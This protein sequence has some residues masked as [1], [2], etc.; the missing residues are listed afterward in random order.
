MPKTTYGEDGGLDRSR[1]LAS[2]EKSSIAAHDEAAQNEMRGVRYRLKIQDDIRSQ[3]QPALRQKKAKKVHFKRYGVASLGLVS[4]AVL[5][6]IALL[7]PSM[8]LV[9]MK[10]QLVNDLNDSTLAYYTYAKKVMAE[11]VGGGSCQEKT[12]EC[13]FRSM[14]TMLKERYEE[15]GFTLQSSRISSSDRHAVASIRAPGGEQIHSAAA[16]KKI[17]DQNGGAT[18]RI[19][20]VLDPK[21]ALFHDRKF[22]D[23]LYKKFHI[24]H[25]QTLSGGSRQE[26]EESFDRN[27]WSDDDSIDGYGRGVFGLDYLSQTESQW[28]GEIYQKI[29]EKAKT[30]LA[31]TCGM[32]TYAT[33]MEGAIIQAKSTTLARFAMQYLAT[34]DALKAGVQSG[35]QEVE[36]LADRLSTIDSSGI[37]A[38][39]GSSYRVPAMYESPDSEQLPFER[40]YMNDA[41]LPLKIVQALGGVF[42]L[43]GTTY[44]QKAASSLRTTPGR[45][46]CV[47]GIAGAQRAQEQS[48]QCLD[49]GIGAVAQY[50]GPIGLA[51]T[52]V[53]QFR[54]MIQALCAADL[55]AVVKIAQTLTGPEASFATSSLIGPALKQEYDKF[56]SQTYGVAA[57]DAIFSGTGVL[58]G[59]VAQSI[60]MR[61]ASKDSLRNYL[62]STKDLRQQLEQSERLA[63]RSAP[64]DIANPY[65]FIG[66]VMRR[67][68]VVAAS[69]AANLTSTGLAVVSETFSQGLV[70]M[71][72][73]AA[74][75]L[76]SQPANHHWQRLLSPNQ[77]SNVGDLAINP[78]FGCN[79][80][81]SMSQNDLNKNVLDVVR[82]MSS[83]TADS[84]ALAAADTGADNEVGQRMQAE[85]SEGSGATFIDKVTGAPNKHTEYA[86]F[87]DYCTNRTMPWGYVGMKTEYTPED[88]SPDE[89]MG[90]RGV[91]TYSHQNYGRSM[92]NPD[93]STDQDLPWAY[94]GKAWGSDSDYDWMTGKK[95][96]EESEML[97]NFRAY[98]VMCR[99]LAGMSG[100]KECWHEDAV[101]EFNSGFYPRNNIIFIRE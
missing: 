86:K 19:Y 41:S 14:S 22:A 49:T 29:T 66:S 43:P 45:E 70:G 99:A 57:Q 93:A 48:G 74:S 77:C 51:A 11:Q 73:P 87:L 88:Y 67:V 33:V 90:P 64:W 2:E 81:Y 79:V 46:G 5:I 1:E 9:N 78:D 91:R 18:D 53:P 28:R 42:G 35:D 10:E 89:D 65:S 25:Y 30:H 72:A 68:G 62:T 83:N 16:F 23:R 26:V 100:T 47:Q 15:R 20:D 17:L 60:G 63:A 95:C 21:N 101:P 3:S 71:A 40:S 13:K 54:Q 61:P 85:S 56:S 94:Y 50:I 38:T 31:L 6:G 27:L 80:R 92:Q 24:P 55:T 69:E 7:S 52:Q 75:A 96:L 98:T 76:Y 34:A 84:G 59:D 32:D 37:A 4:V 97:N 12:I 44:L 58:L 82:Y 8:I 39:D 36:F